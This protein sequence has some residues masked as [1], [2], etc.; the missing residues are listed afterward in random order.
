MVK[1]EIVQ[2]VNH[3][4]SFLLSSVSAITII[5]LSKN[6][7]ATVFEKN[8]ASLSSMFTLLNKPS[9]MRFSI[10]EINSFLVFSNRVPCSALKKNQQFKPE[11]LGYLQ[12]VM[13]D[14]VPEILEGFALAGFYVA[15][16][17]A[18]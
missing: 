3:L 6:E 5:R 15:S 17:K 4:L 10:S 13:V 12:H 1:V 7:R 8:T 14:F 16:D 9:Y 2:P 18:M 11:F